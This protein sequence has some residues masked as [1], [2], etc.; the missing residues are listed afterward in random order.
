[1]SGLQT[2]MLSKHCVR[3][4]EKYCHLTCKCL[5]TMQCKFVLVPAESDDP[6][7]RA[8]PAHGHCRVVCFHPWSDITLPLM[9][10][11][12]IRHVV[13]T[14]INENVTLGKDFDWVQVTCPDFIYMIGNIIKRLRFIQQGNVFS[15]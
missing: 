1:M 4:H 2:S 10:V 13:D 15:C 7:F 8:A 12:D 11:K 9:D 5:L 3:V 6:L 14:W